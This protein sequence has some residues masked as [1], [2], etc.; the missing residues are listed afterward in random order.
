MPT[1]I[2]AERRWKEALEIVYPGT[3]FNPELLSKG[4]D[5]GISGLPKEEHKWPT[6]PVPPCKAEDDAIVNFLKDFIKKGVVETI[7]ETKL[8]PGERFLLCGIL[9]FCVTNKGVK[10]G[11]LICDF[12]M[13]KATNQMTRVVG[14]VLYERS[15]PS[16][17]MIR[18]CHL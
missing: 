2:D 3:C 15:V 9:L 7:D 5:T 17:R 6:R 13:K 11:R 12:S 4:H 18:K 10:W 8:S 16:R 1:E 14:W